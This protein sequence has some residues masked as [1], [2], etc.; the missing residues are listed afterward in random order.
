MPCDDC[1]SRREFLSRST[2]AVA[3]VAA[4][5][6]GCGDGHFGPTALTPTNTKISLKV[7]SLPGLATAGQ[8]VKLSQ[9]VGLIAVTRTGA[10]T[11]AAISTVCTHQGCEIDVTGTTFECPC[12]NSRFDTDGHV[13][14]QP[15][16]TDG[17]ATNLLTYATQYDVATDT[18]TIG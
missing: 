5:A 13:T 8:P 15:Q 1:L 6:A 2:L 18:L 3:G 16:G 7:S 4:V 12:H 14:R 11:F 17:S 10:A 9:S